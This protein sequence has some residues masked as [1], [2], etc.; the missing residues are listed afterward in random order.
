VTVEF[1]VFFRETN[2]N[3]VIAVTLGHDDTKPILESC[4]LVFAEAV[5]SGKSV[6]VKFYRVHQSQSLCS[7]GVDLEPDS[8]RKGLELAT[9]RLAVDWSSIFFLPIGASSEHLADIGLGVD[10]FDSL[11]TDG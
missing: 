1:T 11:S 7:N 4:S 2:A 3:E 8:P 10:E 6:M 5:L 9:R